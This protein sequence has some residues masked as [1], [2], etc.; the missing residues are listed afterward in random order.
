MD[1]LRSCLSYCWPFP[2]WRADRYESIYQ[3]DLDAGTARL[4]DEQELVMFQDGNQISLTLLETGVRVE[5][6]QKC[7]PTPSACRLALMP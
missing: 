1:A 3:W 4:S 2:R 5:T 7:T 6:R